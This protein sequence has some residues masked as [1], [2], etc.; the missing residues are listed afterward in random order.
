MFRMNWM[1]AAAFA[2]IVS[3]SPLLAQTPAQTP[4]PTAPAQPPAAPPQT[5]TP[6]SAPT[7]TVTPAPAATPT[8]TPATATSQMPSS[9]PSPQTPAT[10]GS[11]SAPLVDSPHGTAIALL[12][13][14]QTVLDKAVDGKGDQIS[15]DRGLVDE[16]RAE[17]TQVKLTLQAEKR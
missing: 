6:A 2:V 15:L 12:D 1:S 3:T 14:V 13:R 10:G 4:T 9:N 16:M 7:P 8:T 5:Q 11:T 17:L